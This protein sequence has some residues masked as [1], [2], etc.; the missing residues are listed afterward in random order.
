MN[1]I[2]KTSFLTK[3]AAFVLCAA[4]SI[5]ANANTIITNATS[6]QPLLGINGTPGIDFAMEATVVWGTSSLSK[7]FYAKTSDGYIRLADKKFWPNSFIS[8][9]DII[10]V[11]GKTVSLQYQLSDNNNYPFVNAD[12]HSI[13]I[14]DHTTPEPPID[15]KI[16]A[17]PSGKYTFRTVRIQGIVRDGFTDEIDH[18]YRHIIISSDNHSIGLS[19][20]AE[21]CSE[22]T[23]S[24]LIGAEIQAIGYY[25]PMFSGYR[26]LSKCAIYIGSTNNITIISHPP[27]DPFSAPSLESINL[28]VTSSILNLGRHTTKGNVICVWQRGDFAVKTDNGSIVNVRLSSGLPPN[29]GEYVEV[30]GLPDTDLYRI[31]LKRAIWRKGKSSSTYY[32][33]KATPIKPR[34]LFTDGIGN[35]EYKP[36]FHGKAISLTGMI[37]SIPSDISNNGIIHLRCDNFTIKIDASS[38]PSA[39]APLQVGC[40]AKISG[41]YIVKTDSWHPNEPLPRINEVA[42][43]IRTPSDVEIIAHP[44]WWTPKKLLI[45]IAALFITLTGF[46]LW[47]F[48]LRRLSEKR[49]RELLDAQLSQVKSKLKIQERTRIAVELHDTIA[50]NLTGVSLEI[51]SAEQLAAKNQEGMMKHLGMAAR[52]LQ[53]CRNELRNCLWDLRSRALEESSL[54]EAIRR[55]I[56]PQISNVDLSIRFNVERRHLTDDTAHVLMRIIRELVL[57]AVRH[58]EASS[59]KIAGSLENGDTLLFSVSDNGCGFDPQTRPGVAQG[60]FGLQGV[61]ERVNQFDGEMNIESASGKGSRISI[62]MKLS[63]QT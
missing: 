38:I 30:A 43:V 14:I 12:C 60:H 47:N 22:D 49:G 40:K 34:E 19:I 2:S 17:F 13:E 5:A 6:L 46:I 39:L 55:A 31:N 50:Q 45:F 24:Q 1:S 36:D 23:I 57:N 21:E 27:K 37:D 15:A 10:K 52:T 59:V 32:S 54:N 25:T 61:R 9:G 28:D 48:L 29:Y 11:H 51:D 56:A 20:S 8:P 7:T 44:P 33:P 18:K 26:K 63:N 53:S 58:G 35:F 4:F 42:L 16:S 41:T 62:L 3:I